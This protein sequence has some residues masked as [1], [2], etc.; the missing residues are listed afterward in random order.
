MLAHGWRAARQQ[1][2]W[3]II[4]GLFCYNAIQVEIER[5]RVGRCRP[6][7]VRETQYREQG[8]EEQQPDHGDEPRPPEVLLGVG[9]GDVVLMPAYHHGVEVEAVRRT[10][11]RVVFY[12]V[13][14]RFTADLDDIRAKAKGARVLYLTYIA[15]WP[16]PLDEA[17]AIARE[18]G[19]LLVEDVALS[20][21]SRDAAGRPFGAAG[22]LAV[23]CLYKT[24]PVPHGGVALASAPLPPGRAP[25]LL[26]TLHHLGGSLRAHAYLRYGRYG[27][28]GPGAPR[29]GGPG[30]PEGLGDTR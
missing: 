12:R 1:G 20:L 8:A 27:R 6:F 10:G 18:H 22:D 21:F 16:Q 29:P 26:S 7:T 19:L 28:G 13:D 15:G 5:A 2:Q 11:A 3:V 9:D 24:L 4:M 30:A 25:P 14:A 23:F 17:R